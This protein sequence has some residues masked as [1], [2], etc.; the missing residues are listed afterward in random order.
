MPVGRRLAATLLLVALAACSEPFAA[1]PEDRDARPFPNEDANVDG[2]QPPEGSMAPERDVGLADAA[3]GG[4]APPVSDGLLLWLRAD[5][6]VTE[7]RGTISMWA[8]HSGHHSDA[9]QTDPT[10]QPKLGSGGPRAAVVFDTDDFMSLPAGFGDFSAGISMF[11]VFD[12]NADP[13]AAGLCIDVLDLSNGPEV[14]DI[15]LGRH[16]GQVHYEVFNSD[17]H[18]DMLPPG[19]PVLASIV[20]SPDQT[21]QLRLNSAPF[22]VANIELPATITRLSNVVGR[23]LYADCGSMNGGLWETLV[24]GRALNNDERAR[25]E[26]YLQSRWGCCR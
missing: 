4:L 21:V 13:D 8:D 26:S 2:S 25:V 15:T 18:G 23:S 24:Y 6:G 16:D 22:T 14:D 10:K 3:E 11:A 9:V 5:M 19:V 17:V 12:T 20:H 1:A 7:T